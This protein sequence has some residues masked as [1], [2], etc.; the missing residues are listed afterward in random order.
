MKAIYRLL[1][2]VM[3]L[4]FLFSAMSACGPTQ[5]PTQTYDPE[6]L[7]VNITWHQ[8]QP[9]YY[10][11]V[12]GVYTRPWVRVHATKDYYDMASTVAQYPNVHVTFNLTPV[13]IKQLD[14]FA[15]NGA[16]DLYWVLA[17]KPANTL[18][19]DDK[20]FILTRFYDVNWNNIISRFPRYQELLDKRGGTDDAAINK[21]MT[22]FTEQDFRDLQI[23]FKLGLVRSGFPGP[24]TFES[25]DRKRA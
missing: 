18:T 22:S 19:D 1:S 10:K 23:W 6:V 4:V 8:H 24:G 12:D 3:V 9:M 16:K 2:L 13:L 7:F 25:F 15:N 17:E 14:D 21:A 5:T 11:N 20:R